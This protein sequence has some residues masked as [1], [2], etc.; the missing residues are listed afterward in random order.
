M[1]L[2]RNARDAQGP[3]DDLNEWKK[4]SNTIYHLIPHR[5]RVRFCLLWCG[6]AH[7]HYHSA[8]LSSAAS[9]RS[10]PLGHRA[11]SC[12]AYSAPDFSTRAV[13][14]KPD[15]YSFY[16]FGFP[17]WPLSHPVLETSLYPS[18]LVHVPGTA[19]P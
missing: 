14:H 13:S 17:W 12:S 10:S 9:L 8:I 6:A 7:W 18:S 2:L 15:L 3:A 11:A 1:Q 19:S 5:H 16:Y 4:I